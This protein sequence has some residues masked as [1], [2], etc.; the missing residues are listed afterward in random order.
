[1]KKIPGMQQYFED[2]DEEEHQ[3][4]LE[5][6]IGIINSMTHGELASPENINAERTD[7]I[8]RGSGTSRKCVSELLRA[9]RDM[10]DLTVR[11]PNGFV[12]LAPGRSLR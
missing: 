8:A 5:R 3:L 6:M 7:R 11:L 1:M 10:R 12:T 4:Y 9:Y 2:F